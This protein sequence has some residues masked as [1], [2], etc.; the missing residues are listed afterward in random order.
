M[1]FRFKLNEPL[2]RGVRRIALAQLEVAERRLKDDPVAAVHEVRKSLKRIRA[3]LRLAR[4]A[5]G[6]KIYRAEN[7]HL[8]E[9]GRSLSSRRDRDV[10]QV[11]LKKLE[12]QLPADKRDVVA[13]LCASLAAAEVPAKASDFRK[14]RS[15]LVQAGKRFAKL[16]PQTDEFRALEEG[17]RKSY[18][19]GLRALEGALADR[20]DEVFHD[21]R[22]AVQQHWRQML[23]LSKAWPEVC[24]AR[25]SSARDIAQILGEEHDYAVL[26]AHV[27]AQRDGAISD[28][29]ARLVVM[30]CQSRQQELRA[31]ALPMAKR[32]FALPAG[33]FTRQIAAS[34][35]AA[36]EL[37]RLGHD[38]PQEGSKQ[39]ANGAAKDAHGQPEQPERPSRAE[40]E[41]RDEH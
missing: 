36:C 12:P 22:K 30:H 14:V 6:D 2:S 27:G 40:A 19:S 7:A 8:R 29:E 9:L 38:Q 25:A 21:L 41:A 28:A 3:L 24:R 18:K 1:A 17:L 5:L 32:L 20:D 11:T 4:P 39:G 15:A 35:T 34:W 10:M 33:S 26:A 13:R 23:L 16:K 31:M 37:A